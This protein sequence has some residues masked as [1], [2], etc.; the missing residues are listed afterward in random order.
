MDDTDFNLWINGNPRPDGSIAPAI[1]I[2]LKVDPATVQVGGTGTGPIKAD[3][4]VG[5]GDKPLGASIGIGGGTAVAASVAANLVKPLSAGITAALRTLP[6]I[7]LKF[8]EVP[9][10]EVHAPSRIRF[11]FRVLG[12]EVWALSLRGHS[13]FKSE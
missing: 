7:V 12:F 6:D 2:Q 4:G 8:K 11:G 13:T 5:G 9:R 1:P 3:L 10:F